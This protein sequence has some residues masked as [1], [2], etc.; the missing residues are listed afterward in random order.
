[1]L[2]F[3][4]KWAQSIRNNVI[5]LYILICSRH[6]MSN[7]QAIELHSVIKKI[8]TQFQHLCVKHTSRYSSPMVVVSHVLDS[9]KRFAENN[10]T[11]IRHKFKLVFAINRYVFH[12]YKAVPI[13]TLWD[14]ARI[15]ILC[16][17][18]LL[19]ALY[20]RFKLKRRSWVVR[21]YNR[22]TLMDKTLL[23]IQTTRLRS[24]STNLGDFDDDRCMNLKALQT[25]CIQNIIEIQIQLIGYEIW[26]LN[27]N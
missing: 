22:D 12:L 15:T 26:T 5:I 10:N 21:H 18:I 14:I 16:I 19:L 23:P 27:Y 24:A 3:P 1:M 8:V 7:V 4:L 11:Y 17:V 9:M 6:C 20:K 13:H 25:I 2:R